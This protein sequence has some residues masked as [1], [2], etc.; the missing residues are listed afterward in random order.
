MFDSLREANEEA[1]GDS[2]EEFDDSD[3]Q[4]SDNGKEKKEDNLDIKK[5]SLRVSRLYKNYKNLLDIKGVILSRALS[6]V[7][8]TH[9]DDISKL[10]ED[11]LAD[12]HGIYTDENEPVD[13]QAPSAIG[14]DAPFG[15]G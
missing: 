8:E 7:A 10:L 6:F 13:T 14:A 9:G 1:D 2:E 4:T 11:H 3:K 15:G 5:F 12:T